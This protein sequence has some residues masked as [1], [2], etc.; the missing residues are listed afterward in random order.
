MSLGAKLHVPQQPLQLRLRPASGRRCVPHQL[1]GCVLDVD[2]VVGDV[3]DQAA[4][5][6]V[7]LVLLRVQRYIHTVALANLARSRRSH[8]TGLLQTCVSQQ[9]LDVLRVR[10]VVPSHVVDPEPALQKKP[11]DFMSWSTPILPDTLHSKFSW[12][13]PKNHSMS[14][15]MPMA[16]VS[17]PW[18]SR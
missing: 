9:L 18:F 16:R 2:A 4:L 5:L 8:A 11:S 3:L 17:S 15:A 14:S 6:P 13:Q 12:T 7:E 10:L 1:L